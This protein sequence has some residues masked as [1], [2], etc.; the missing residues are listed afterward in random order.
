MSNDKD[1]I[2]ELEI[3]C[4]QLNQD[5]KRMQYDNEYLNGQSKL[6]CKRID[7]LQ[8][9]SETVDPLFKMIQFNFNDKIGVDL[10]VET[11]GV[12]IVDQIQELDKQITI[13]NH[14]LSD[15]EEWTRR[16]EDCIYD[17]LNELDKKYD[18]LVKDILSPMKA[19]SKDFDYLNVR[20]IKIENDIDKF[21]AVMMEQIPE[22]IEE[23][24]KELRAELFSRPYVFNKKPHKCPV[25][26]GMRT[27]KK[28]L[29][30]ADQM[31]W[32]E[33]NCICCEGKGIVWG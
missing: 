19:C 24:L 26:E 6:H 28:M 31:V 14:R 15:L 5:F 25:C 10:L 1:R 27:H 21:K 23:R 22:E 4:R 2:S 20:L 7:E 17:R 12:T 18:Q 29:M 32:V 3:L 16:D 8:E 30:H 9:A 11:E 13:L 33:D